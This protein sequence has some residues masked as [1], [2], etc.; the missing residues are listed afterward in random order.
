MHFLCSTAMTLVEEIA[1][2]RQGEIDAMDQYISEGKK[3]SPHRWR[4]RFL[5]GKEPP[6]QYFARQEDLRLIRCPHK[7]P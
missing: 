6:S 1:T 4:V 3:L 2:Q 5:D 7:A